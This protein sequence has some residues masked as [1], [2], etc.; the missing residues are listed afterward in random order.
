MTTIVG[1]L[2]KRE[3]LKARS[4]N[5]AHLIGRGDGRSGARGLIGAREAFRRKKGRLHQCVGGGPGCF[6]SRR[7]HQLFLP[8]LVTVLLA[9]GT[10]I[11]NPLTS[12]LLYPSPTKSR[13][14]FRTRAKS[15][16]GR[17][18]GPPA[19]GLLFEIHSHPFGV[20]AF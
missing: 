17:V 6:S 15:F 4:Q 14:S 18:F 19:T 9:F 2:V 20:G 10:G 12:L 16:L 11:V 13:A 1:K 7:L 3:D 8:M 5:H